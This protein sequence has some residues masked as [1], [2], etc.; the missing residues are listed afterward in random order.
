MIILPAIDL[1]DGKVVR[2]TKGD[3]NKL[4]EYETDPVSMAL[5]FE[6]EGAKMLHIVDLNGAKD[7]YPINYKSLK[8]VARAVEIPIE[9]GGGVRDIETIYSYFDLGISRI[10]LGTAAILDRDFAFRASDL[11]PDRI[12][13]GLD[14]KDGKPAVKGWHETVKEDPLE[15]ASWFA[16]IGISGIILTD[17]SKDGMMSGTNIEMLEKFATSLDINVIASGGISSLDDLAKIS[18]L[19]KDNI[20][21]A[22]IGK[23]L[24]EK[25]ID[26]VDAI[27]IVEGS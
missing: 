4:V 13:I 6:S 2:L 25:T 15:L 5:K 21:G 9:L 7:G 18:Q 11:F 27:K 12:Y 1:V 3:Y 16:T 26:L 8:E 10:I 19:N 17:I 20:E 14:I 23:A 24:Y 22:I